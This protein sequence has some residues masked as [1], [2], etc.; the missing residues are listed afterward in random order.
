[1][2]E[3]HQLETCYD[4]SF[5]N[6]SDLRSV[7]S[8][9][10][11]SEFLGKAIYE[12]EGYR[13]PTEAELLYATRS[14]STYPFWSEYGGGSYNLDY[15][16]SDVEISDGNGSTLGDYAW[17]CGNSGGTLNAVAKK[18]PNEFGLYDTIGNVIEQVHDRY[19][20]SFPAQSEDPVYYDT[21][22]TTT[23]IRG[24][25]YNASPY[26]LKNSYRTTYNPTSRSVTHGVRLARSVTD[27]KP[28]MPYVA[29]ASVPAL[30]SE[31][32]HCSIAFHL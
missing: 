29:F 8:C 26:Y 13:L 28:T 9:S 7:T 5:S 21:S 25:A 18:L 19:Q 3:L 30:T 22:T 16:N 23:V 12:C 20:S 32:L 4:C 15:C 11:K 27:S 14:N 24:G 6:S 31:D 10:P 2:S 17:F 1:M